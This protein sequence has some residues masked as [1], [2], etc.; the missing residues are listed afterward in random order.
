MK[1]KRA[2]EF[3]S[4]ARFFICDGVNFANGAVNFPNKIFNEVVT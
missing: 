1:D 4:P 3:G 2:G